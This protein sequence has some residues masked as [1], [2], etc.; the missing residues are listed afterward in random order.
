MANLMIEKALS[1]QDQIFAGIIWQVR[2]D[3]TVSAT[4]ALV[5][6]DAGLKATLINAN[7]LAG[8]DLS[9][10]ADGLTDD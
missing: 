8:E 1:G 2:E 3:N 9:Y 10:R 4:G 6:L 7:V 5:I